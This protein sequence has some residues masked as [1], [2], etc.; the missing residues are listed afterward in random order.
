MQL[1]T[2]LFLLQGPPPPY[3]LPRQEVIQPAPVKHNSS[4]NDHSI[5]CDQSCNR[6]LLLFKHAMH[7]I[8]PQ[9]NPCTN[10]VP[11]DCTS[12]TKE[13]ENPYIDYTEALEQQSHSKPAEDGQILPMNITHLS[14]QLQNLIAVH[15]L[16]SKLRTPINFRTLQTKLALHPDQVFM[17]QLIYNLQY[18][19]NIS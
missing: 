17:N 9:A 12:S 8:Y 5:E 10:I 4:H 13:L 11:L 14:Q 15:Q 2:Y 18:G 1:S 6:S 16:D 3:L 19:C 7:S